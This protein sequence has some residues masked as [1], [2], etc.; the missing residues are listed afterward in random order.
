[1]YLK[2]TTALV[3]PFKALLSSWEAF[4]PHAVLVS[5][6]ASSSTALLLPNTAKLLKV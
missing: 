1:M 6:S 5:F 3:L 2:E 4:P